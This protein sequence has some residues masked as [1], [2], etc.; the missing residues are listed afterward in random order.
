MRFCFGGTVADSVNDTAQTELRKSILGVMT[1]PIL[2]DPQA[3]QERLDREH[4]DKF[5]D[6][7]AASDEVGLSCKRAG[8]TR[9]QFR[10]WQVLD[11]DFAA[12]IEA[13]HEAS[14]DEVQSAIKNIALNTEL[15]TSARVQAAKLYLESQRPS[16]YRRDQSVA[17]HA[18]TTIQFFLGADP[19]VTRKLPAVSA[20]HNVIEAEVVDAKED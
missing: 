15:P 6:A 10:Q 20:D 19:T 4:K 2:I 13:L 3:E 12:E 9:Q 5:L 14:V 8:I 17:A 11:V 16:E 18:S 1:P 7:Y